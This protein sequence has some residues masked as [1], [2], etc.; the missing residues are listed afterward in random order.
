MKPV[1]GP[2]SGRGR[3]H[4][5]LRGTAFRAPA[6]SDGAPVEPSRVVLAGS[7]R[8]AFS[9]YRRGWVSAERPDHLDREASLKSLATTASEASI[10]AARRAVI[11]VLRTVGNPTM[12]G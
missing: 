2:K 4:E 1:R 11:R 9:T 7:G 5:R 6:T 3:R 10:S 8:R 12:S